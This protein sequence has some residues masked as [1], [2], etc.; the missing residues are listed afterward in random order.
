M[1]G[2]ELGSVMKIHQHHIPSPPPIMSEKRW[3]GGNGNRG[4]APLLH[5]TEIQLQGRTTAQLDKHTMTGCAEAHSTS[6]VTKRKCK[7]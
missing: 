1:R 7:G 2:R 6:K 5:N 4:L 3:G